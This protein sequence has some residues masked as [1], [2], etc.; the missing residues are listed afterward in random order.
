MQRGVLIN[1]VVLSKTNLRRERG[2]D[3]ECDMLII[4]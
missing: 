1:L 4:S 3:L 2:V